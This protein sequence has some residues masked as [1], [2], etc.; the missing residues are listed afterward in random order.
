MVQHVLTTYVVVS[1]GVCL[2]NILIKHRYRL[3]KYEARATQATS[4]PVSSEPVSSAPVSSAPS[5]PVSTLN[6][7]DLISPY[8]DAVV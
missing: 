8:M 4:A 7:T 1:V 5:E 2:N 6:Q 3:D